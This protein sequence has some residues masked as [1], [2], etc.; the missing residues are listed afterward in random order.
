MFAL[1]P[2]SAPFALPEIG[3]RPDGNGLLIEVIGR[4]GSC[5][6]SVVAD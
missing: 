1:V 3:S 2:V 5:C 4:F 6:R